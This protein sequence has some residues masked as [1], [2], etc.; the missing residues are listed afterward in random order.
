MKRA[1]MLIMIGVML[2][3]TGAAFAK[4]VVREEPLKWQETSNLD[5]DQLYG[6]ICAVCHGAGGKGD[7][8]AV[9]A[10]QR[11]VPDLTVISTR[12]SGV[13]PHKKV[14]YIIFGDSRDSAHGTLTMPSWGQAFMYVRP[15][16]ET[17][18]REAYAR[19]RIHTLSMYIESLQAE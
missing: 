6:N 14:E 2:L 3:C 8:P 19:E 5:G 11:E 9:A 10:L 1:Y 18:M 16:W 12:N 15:G 7:G 4:I 17:F 13:F